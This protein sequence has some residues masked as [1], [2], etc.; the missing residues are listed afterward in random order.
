MSGPSDETT[1]HQ[2][3]HT[4]AI[5]LMALGLIVLAVHFDVIT[6][7]RTLFFNDITEYHAPIRGFLG[8][9]WARGEF[10]LWTPDIYLGFPIF[11][12][13]QGGPLYPLNWLLFTWLPAWQGINISY[14]LHL[15]IGGAGAFILF[16]MFLGRAG[17]FLGAV[18]F[19]LSGFMAIHHI[20]LNMIQAGAW[21]PFVIWGIERGLRSGRFRDFTIAIAFMT[22]LAFAGHPQTTVQT[23]LFAGF[24]GLWRGVLS[25]N[26]RFIRNGLA[27]GLLAGL[28][29]VASAGVYMVHVLPGLELAMNSVRSEGT[30]MAEQMQRFN[31]PQIFAAMG[32]ASAFGTSAN[33][34]FW[35]APGWM[36]RPGFD[37][38]LGVLPP[39]LAVIAAL[40]DRRPITLIFVLLATGI[41]LVTMGP[42]IV[43]IP[44]FYRLPFLKGLRFPDRF[45]LQLAFAIAYLA[46]AGLDTVV[47]T[48]ITDR[49]IWIIGVLT[50]GF[51]ATI[52]FWTYAPGF[53]SRQNLADE[54]FRDA[55]IMTGSLLVGI[56]GL[57]LAQTSRKTAIFIVTVAVMIPLGDYAHRHVPTLDPSYWDTPKTVT[58][59]KHDMC[60]PSQPCDRKN[61]LDRVA[62]LGVKLS[63]L[64]MGWLADEHRYDL[65]LDGLSYNQPMLWGLP[66]VD[67]LLPLRSSDFL[68]IYEPL[69]RQIRPSFGVFGARYVV[70]PKTRSLPTMTLIHDDALRVYR[71]DKAL[72]RVMALHSIQEVSSPAL[73]RKLMID[74]RNLNKVALV[75]LP[76]PQMSVKIPKDGQSSVEITKYTNDFVTIRA[77]MMADGIVVL[78]D[79]Y[80]PGWTATVDERPTKIHKV[81][82]I[83]RGVEVPKGVHTIAFEYKPTSII[84]GAAISLG[85]IMALVMAWMLSILLKNRRPTLAL[86]TFDSATSPSQITTRFYLYVITGI[87]G[88]LIL[89]IIVRLDLFMR[90]FER[91]PWAR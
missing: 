71:D 82:S 37:L 8:S 89:S 36:A 38:F 20:H 90:T 56:L 72:N 1:R 55:V 17:A 75:D 23:G 5:C 28:V 78:L 74:G 33:G 42:L 69:T 35:F 87:G 81:D 19:T 59:I 41:I 50:A 68:G 83:Y 27:G 54:V 61:Q 7:A 73:V 70:T 32:L 39:I 21:Q 18:V 85:T 88:W 25:T 67:G 62:F 10:P 53:G 63:H 4:D 26:G 80:Y 79:R 12:E 3:D 66:A 44:E 2:L 84:R 22:L 52:M 64:R 91:F 43:G 65:A 30:S 11:A 77:N 76:A 13:G 15:F 9:A 51:I 29:I 6:L 49:L 40:R 57:M 16:R 58:A 34:T 86:P 14:V 47:K 60:P 24:Y 31:T 45:N 46:G 48:H